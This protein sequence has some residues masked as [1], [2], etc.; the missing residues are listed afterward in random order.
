MLDNGGEVDLG[1]GNYERFLDLQLS[2]DNKITTGKIYDKVLRREREGL[3]IG[4]T[5]QVIPHITDTSKERIEEVSNG[6]DPLTTL[7]PQ[8]C[9]IDLV[10]TV[11]DIESMPFVEALRQLHFELGDENFCSVF[12]S[13][14]PCVRESGEHKTIFTGFV[15]EYD[16]LQF[17]CAASNRCQAEACYF[18]SGFHRWGIGM[19]DLKN[20]CNIPLMLQEQ[21]VCKLLISSLKLKWKIPV[22]FEKWK[23]MARTAEDASLSPMTIFIVGEYTCNTDA[24]ISIKQALQHAAMALGYTLVIQLSS[25]S[26]LENLESN[27]INQG[28]ARDNGETTSVAENESRTEFKTPHESSMAHKRGWEQLRSAYGILVPGRFGKRGVEGKMKSI[29]YARN[30]DKPCLGICLGM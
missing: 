30:S 2:S 11:G 9:V 16:C 13:F 8:I 1:L 23:A 27:R 20:R 17:S 10:G 3:K 21:G 22:R 5:V 25:S 12:V 15:T 6:E 24:Y 4:R 7:S 26:D 29:K 18:L 14:V 28:T 19:H